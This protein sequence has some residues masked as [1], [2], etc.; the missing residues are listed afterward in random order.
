MA[1][2]FDGPVRDPALFATHV[3]D[4][5]ETALREVCDKP[6]PRFDIE[7]ERGQI[8]ADDPLLSATLKPGLPCPAPAPI[9]SATP[10]PT[11]DVGGFTLF[12][13][14]LQGIADPASPYVLQAGSVIPAALVTGLRS[15]LPGQ[16]TAQVT[17]HAYDSP[18][19]HFLLIP[20]GARLIGE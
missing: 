4:K 14:Q 15:D 19:G 13:I 8:A 1:R 6:V 10:H 18:T 11:D 7:L 16:I 5:Q 3:L 12:L 20:Q 9:G 2:E 17:Q